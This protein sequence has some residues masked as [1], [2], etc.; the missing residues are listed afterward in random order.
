MSFDSVFNGDP[1][2]PGVSASGKASLGVN[3]ATGQLYVKDDSVAGWQKNA[4]GIGEVA[5]VNG[6]T[7]TVEL[8]S[9][10]IPNESTV[11][12]STVTDVLDTLEA[13][14]LPL[15]GAPAMLPL[16]T[17]AFNAYGDS[18]TIGAGVANK[19]QAY[20]QLVAAALGVPVSNNYGLSGQDLQQITRSAYENPPTI[21]IGSLTLLG[22]N[23]AGDIPG[24]YTLAQ[25]FA[26]Q[27][28]YAAWT[29]VPTDQIVLA[30][31]MTYTGSWSTG[32]SGLPVYY[33]TGTIGNTATAVVS[34]TTVY[35]GT[36]VFGGLVTA[37]TVTIDGVLVD[38]QSITMPG[39]PVY[40]CFRYPGLS[41]GNHTVVITA[42][43]TSDYA[44]V[45]WVA[46]NGGTNKPLSLMGNC[47]NGPS[48]TITSI[49]A[50]LA[51]IAGQLHSDG[52]QS[53]VVDTAAAIND[54]SY[55]NE[56]AD[57]VH[58]NALG[59]W[60]ISDAFLKV[61]WASSATAG[62]N[63]QMVASLMQYLL[64]MPQPLSQFVPTPSTATSAG[65]AGMWATDGS[66]LYVCSG[67]NAWV[68]VA[69]VT[70]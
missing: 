35:V 51:T 21:A 32:A 1:T 25:Y 43:T 54:T 42:N 7:G 67:T 16:S 24:Q 18:I 61:M 50:Q 12:G 58:P 8:T 3:L 30:A 52:L 56:F 45:Q 38:T 70:W 9:T 2:T 47:I 62:L 5:S 23:D 48:S 63:A 26:Q 34:G 15:I 20:P 11:S 65:Q 33:S 44:A 29:A 64:Q 36:F 22:A 6:K 39:A 53:Y 14:S 10:D 31:A 68:R 27:M 66:F 17:T 28:A 49:N 37:F 46:A 60:L 4:G 69:V 40:Q 13:S 55:P 57:S 19:S 59:N 41:S